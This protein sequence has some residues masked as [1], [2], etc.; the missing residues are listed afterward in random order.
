M[1]KTWLPVPIFILVCVQQ[2]I[3]GSSI[4]G[5]EPALPL[6]FEESFAEGVSHWQPTDPEAWTLSRDGNRTVWGLN[7]RKSDYQPKVRSPHN[8][9]LV[10][11]INLTDTVITFEVKSTLDTG[12][13]RD[14]CV[15]FNY[16]D[17]EH[18]Y[19]VHLGARPDPNSGQIMIVD[20]APRRPLT[21]NTRPVPWDDDWHVVKLERDAE[22]GRIA[23]YFD[24]MDRPLMEATDRTFTTGQVGIGSFDDMNNFANVKVY[25][26]GMAAD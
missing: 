14:C 6:V 1:K 7:R 4:H 10:K 19:Y 15:F 20:G 21:E 24:D 11:N 5:A 26:R 18:F 12:N 23:V 25:G 8:I 22:G 9:A 3:A 16:R 13:H 2:L 17:A